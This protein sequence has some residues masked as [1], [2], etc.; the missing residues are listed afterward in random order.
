MATDS[1]GVKS[2]TGQLQGVNRESPRAPGSTVA[3]PSR[4]L[5][6]P[7]DK[8]RGP[9]V[10][11]VLQSPHQEPRFNS[12]AHHTRKRRRPSGEH[13]RASPIAQHFAAQAL[14]LFG[15]SSAVSFP[16][17]SS[18]P[19]SAIS[20]PS[21]SSAAFSPPFAA[22]HAASSAAPRLFLLFRRLWLPSGPHFPLRP[23]RPRPRQLPRLLSPRR[24]LRLPLRP[25]SPSRPLRLPP[26]PLP[27]TS[28]PRLRLWST[29]RP[30]FPL[31]PFRRRPRS[32]LWRVTL[33]PLPLRSHPLP[34]A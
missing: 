34:A 16:S 32:H 10:L 23:P 33:L 28:C 26:W 12:N 22:S 25:H 15:R 13:S 5:P 14:R 31:R 3:Q 21:V 29:L 19:P 27:R 17:A 9:E 7:R 11:L 30:R 4:R 24:R 8:H 2:H 6:L 1:R 18:T 20:F